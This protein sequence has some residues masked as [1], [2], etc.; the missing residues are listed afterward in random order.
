MEKKDV[1]RPVFGPERVAARERLKELRKV[2][3]RERRRELG[4]WKPKTPEQWERRRASARRQY[5]G[6]SAE[7]RE[8][9]L[10]NA[11]E[12]YQ[13]LDI[14]G[15]RA[16]WRTPRQLAYRAAYM[17][18]PE[19]VEQRRLYMVSYNAANRDRLAKMKRDA[20]VSESASEREIRLETGRIYAQL[21]K[22]SGLRKKKGVSGS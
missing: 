2:R 7:R 11:R 6:M 17:R 10:A 5:A 3:E 9:I 16:R 19:V 1:Y 13:A 12:R 8:R 15:R 14:E 21:L 18:R 22:L 20:R 4:Y